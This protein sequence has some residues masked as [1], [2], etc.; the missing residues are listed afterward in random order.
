MR[1]LLLL[2]AFGLTLSSCQKF[3]K[4]E[5]TGSINADAKLSSYQSGIAIANAT[6]RTLPDWIWPGAGD[7]YTGSLCG[8]REFLTGKA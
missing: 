5:P 2:I 7:G 1:K 6:Y 8:S 4:E 3:L